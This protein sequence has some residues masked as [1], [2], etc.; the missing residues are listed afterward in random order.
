M[1]FGQMLNYLMEERAVYT[2]IG[3]NCLSETAKKI[4]H[5][6]DSSQDRVL[7]EPFFYR[8]CVRVYDKT[9][10]RVISSARCFAFKE[11]YAH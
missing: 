6:V 2:H 3:K 8:K 7:S 4:N 11:E 10:S 1:N 9:P 5:F